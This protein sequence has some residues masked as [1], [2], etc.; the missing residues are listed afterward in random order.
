MIHAIELYEKYKSDLDYILGNRFK[1]VYSIQNEP[2]IIIDTN[3]IKLN[4]I[5]ICGID[6]I[7][8]LQ[9]ELLVD[10]RDANYNDLFDTLKRI[11]SIKNKIRYC[12]HYEFSFWYD[13]YKFCIEIKNKEHNTYVE[14]NNK[15]ECV[16]E[17]FGDFLSI[18][19]ISYLQTLFENTI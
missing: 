18:A 8:K 6:N 11:E 2:I 13:N 14:Y 19:Q 3:P 4:R 15:L 9:K 16:T 17:D 7:S 10:F 5:E 1:D 12:I